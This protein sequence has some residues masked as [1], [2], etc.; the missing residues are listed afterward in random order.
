VPPH[1]GIAPGIDRLTMIL[2]GEPNIR[3]VIAFP[4]NQQALD[5]MAGRPVAGGAAAAYGASHPGRGA[6]RRCAQRDLRGH[7]LGVVRLSRL[8]YFAV[9]VYHGSPC[10]D[11][12]AGM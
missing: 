4:K 3:E 5:V 6:G 12:D 1:G 8:R 11:R 10:R 2:A 7:R 9:V